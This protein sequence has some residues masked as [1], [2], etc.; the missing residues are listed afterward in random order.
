ME[1]KHPVRILGEIKGGGLGQLLRCVDAAGYRFVAK[2]PKDL[3]PENQEMVLDEERR[4]LRCQGDHVVRYLGSVQLPDG[5][6]GYA[7]EEMA[8]SLS[9][10]IARR[11]ALSE[12]S[13]LGYIH[14][15]AA[16]LLEVHRSAPG[17]FHGDVKPGNILVRDAST[18]LADFGLAR[19]GYGQTVM[20]GPHTGGTPGYMPPEG[21]ASAAGDVY[22]LGATLAALLTGSEAGPSTA[23]PRSMTQA[24]ASLLR[25]MMETEPRRRPTIERVLESLPSVI[26]AAKARRSEAI[27]NGL[28]VAAAA[29]AFFL[30]VPLLVAA[31]AKSR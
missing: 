4:L 16:G 31:V 20:V 6:L 5:R 8:E 26:E 24:V 7:M 28:G 13:A 12:V 22:S 15:A 1:F 14:G 25:R 2:V 10:V 19:G 29:L 30:F 27:S 17:A 21:Y 23:L 3:S 9:A 11:G 18:K